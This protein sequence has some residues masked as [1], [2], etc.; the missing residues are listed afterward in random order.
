M[1]AGTKSKSI[2]AAL[3]VTVLGLA[4]CAYSPHY[5]SGPEGVYYGR[6]PAATHVRARHVNPAVY[7]YWSLDHFYF[8]GFYHPYSV[9]VGYREPHYYPYPGWIYGYRYGLGHPYRSHGF[10]A[11]YSY[12]YPY[13]YGSYGYP[14]YGSGHHFASFSLGFFVADGH[15][16]HP[17]HNGRHDRRHDLR[18]IDERLARMQQGRDAEVSRSALLGRSGRD[19]AHR[20]P[21]TGGAAISR[22]ARLGAGA[23]DR[24]RILSA[25]ERRSPTAGRNAGRRI[26]RVEDRIRRERRGGTGLERLRGRVIVT[27]AAA[28][29]RAARASS[30][31]D[32]STREALLQSR[33]TQSRQTQSRDINRSAR[34]VFSSPDRARSARSTDNAPPVTRSGL[35]QRSRAGDPGAR[36]RRPATNSAATSYERGRR[37]APDRSPRAERAAHDG[38]GS[39][40]RALLGESRR[41]NRR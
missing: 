8:S 10:S 7:P 2:A 27:D 5:H 41:G 11:R 26:E 20:L 9:F 18:R 29:G 6:A 31:S 33:R 13:G 25:G 19:I 34:R 30:M 38:R 23:R 1:N 37:S 17:R 40:R 24:V 28:T 39:G 3:A 16:G 14:W 15:F 21:R 22:G 32:V 12:G 36:T 35:L 4:G